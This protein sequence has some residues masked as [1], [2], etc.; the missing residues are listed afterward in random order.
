MIKKIV[1][2]NNSIIKGYLDKNPLYSL[3]FTADI[4][5]YEYNNNVFSIYGNFENDNL[6]YMFA[7]FYNTLLLYSNNDNICAEDILDY[8]DKNNITFSILKGK[9]TLTSQFIPYINFTVMHKG[10][11]CSLEEKDFLPIGYDDVAIKKADLSHTERIIGLCNTISEFKGLMNEEIV[12]NSINYGHTYL[13]E[14]NEQIVSMVLCNYINKN[15]A[16]IGSLCTEP[17]YRNRGYATKLLSYICPK[18]LK[19]S[20][21]CSLCYDN[22]KAGKIYSK[23]GFKQAGGLDLYIR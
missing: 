9:N 20:K 16:N 3:F 23:V 22:P 13:I 12:K 19:E 17:K 14:E 5:S 10:Y 8:L 2:E 21:L 4:N 7:L 18:L 11:L 1:Y 15:I 6:T